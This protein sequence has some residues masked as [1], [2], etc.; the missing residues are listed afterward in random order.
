MITSTVG[1]LNDHKQN[2]LYLAEKKKSDVFINV[3]VLLF[4]FLDKCILDCYLSY[5][6]I[7]PNALVLR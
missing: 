5:S 6:N 1:C 2:I 3:E 4:F 7:K